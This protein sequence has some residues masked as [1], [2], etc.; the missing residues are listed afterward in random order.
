MGV[1]YIGWRDCS[2]QR[3]LGPEGFQAKL[4]L[5]AYRSVIEDNVPKGR[6]ESVRLRVSAPSGTRD[7]GYDDIVSAL[8]EFESGIPDCASCPLADGRPLGCYRHVTYPID[9]AFERLLVECFAAHVPDELSAAR[10]L[11]SVLRPRATRGDGPW[12]RLRGTSV[13]SL[14]ELA[15]PLWVEWIDE[16][17]AHAIDSAALCEA[18]FAPAADPEL[19]FLHARFWNELFAWLDLRLARSVRHEE[20][21]PAALESRTLREIHHVSELLNSSVER[22]RSEGWRVLVEA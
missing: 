1:S 15:E 19:V 21:A 8:G 6:R 18:L 4:E 14:A 9:A 12:H 11:W 3:A 7:L 5:R 2:L 17:G 10:R 13:G 16:R 22:A 20:P